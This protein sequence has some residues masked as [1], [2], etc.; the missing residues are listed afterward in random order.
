MKQGKIVEK[1]KQIAQKRQERRTKL[2][3]RMFFFEN[4]KKMLL[5]RKTEFLPKLG[6]NYTK[7]ANCQSASKF[8]FFSKMAAIT[9]SPQTTII[10]GIYHNFQKISEKK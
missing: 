4:G 2:H 8:F 1:S 3:L 7:Q 9:F 10:L 5:D 6:L